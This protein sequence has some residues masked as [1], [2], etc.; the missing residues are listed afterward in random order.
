MH[1]KYFVNYDGVRIG[2]YESVLD[3]QKSISIHDDFKK[4]KYTKKGLPRSNYKELKRFMIT[5]NYGD[6]YYIY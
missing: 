3:A 5:D 2:E 4:S 1:R 6:M